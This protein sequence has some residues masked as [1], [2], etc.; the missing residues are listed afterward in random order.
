MNATQTHRNGA[1]QGRDPQG[2]F[3]NLLAAAPE[4]DVSLAMAS[5]EFSG[6]HQPDFNRPNHDRAMKILAAGQHVEATTR[7]STRDVRSRRG[8]D[9][10]WEDAAAT[11]EYAA[12]PQTSYAKM[13][14]DYTP[15]GWRRTYRTTQSFRDGGQFVTMRAPSKAAMHRYADEVGAPF[16]VP[17]EV[18]M[19]GKA[20]MTWM[21]VT[22]RD[23]NTWSA[24]ALGFRDRRAGQ[25]VAEALMERLEGRRGRT[26]ARAHGSL[27]AAH[28]ERRANEGVALRPLTKESWLKEEGY[29]SEECVSVM[30][31]DSG[32]PYGK[33]LT[34][35]G[36]D[37]VY[38][39]AES[40]GKAWHS[41]SKPAPEVAVWECDNCHRVTTAARKEAHTCPVRA[42]GPTGD[43][44]DFR[45]LAEGAV[46]KARW[47]YRK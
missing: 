17:V 2:R 4:A 19:D 31:T 3:S 14:L 40:A 16:D 10:W 21:R 12:T 24:E 46:A 15:S 45:E 7:H 18:E 33:S 34:R 25:R 35:S 28:R 23:R 42:T 5:D 32:K 26:T 11:A 8:A 47:L 13:P 36:H 22:R 1:V 43:T 30:K 27:A 39:R 44:T 38:H 29:L 6:S 41:V 9:E 37:F 20:A